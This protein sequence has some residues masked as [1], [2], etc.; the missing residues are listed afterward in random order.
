MEGREAAVG[1]VER[2]DKNKGEPGGR[3]GEGGGKVTTLLDL[4][5]TPKSNSAVIPSLE[6]GKVIK[7]KRSKDVTKFTQMN[8]TQCLSTDGRKKFRVAKRRL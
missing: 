6:F 3:A 4:G 7:R 1:E 8:L 2:D 5:F